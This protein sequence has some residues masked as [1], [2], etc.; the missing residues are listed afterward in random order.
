M[1]IKEYMKNT[2]LMASIIVA[3]VAVT[4][5]AMVL[6]NGTETPTGAFES[7]EASWATA[8]RFGEFCGQ[9]GLFA[10]KG[11]EIPAECSQT[12]SQGMLFRA[13]DYRGTY[14]CCSRACLSSE[15]FDGMGSKSFEMCS[16]AC[17]K[18]ASDV[19]TGIRRYSGNPFVVPR[20]NA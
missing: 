4:G 1:T 19:F 10:D 13:N 18:A 6:S 16:S 8:L 3:L 12:T 5:V 15:L 2:Q 9:C 11:M 7:S 20:Y 14:N 17:I